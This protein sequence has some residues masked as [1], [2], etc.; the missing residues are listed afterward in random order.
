MLPAVSSYFLDFTNV[1]VIHILY[2]KIDS[3]DQS[4]QASVWY[5]GASIY[6][7]EILENC[8][9]EKAHLPYVSLSL[10]VYLL[11]FEFGFH[12]LLLQDQTLLE[13]KTSFMSL[14][15]GPYAPKQNLSRCVH[16]F[17]ILLQ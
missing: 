9:P 6:Y 16:V 2:N 3:F 14:H 11:S 15:N 12:D 7:R 13:Y 17:A 5:S 10:V 8:K 1:V 4:V